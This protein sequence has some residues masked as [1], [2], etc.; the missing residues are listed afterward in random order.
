MG[1]SEDQAKKRV[2][3]EPSKS[4]VSMFWIGL[5]SL[6]HAPSF[7]PLP[8]LCR[9]RRRASSILADAILQP[10]SASSSSVV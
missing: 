2:N 4:S 7:N 3:K 8:S 5:C 1:R 10:Y 6:P 9:R